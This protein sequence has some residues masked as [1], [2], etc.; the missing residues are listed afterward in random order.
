MRRPQVKTSLIA[1]M[2]LFA[3][4]F[5]GFAVFAI[6]S[7]RQINNE[8]S[9][10]AKNWLPSVSVV[11]NMGVVLGE[12]R[13]AYAN[14]I[15]SISDEAIAAAEL[16]VTEKRKALDSA[17][18]AYIP[19]ISSAREKQLLDLI[20]KEAGEYNT[21]SEPMLEHS[22]ANDNEVAKVI[23]NSEMNPRFEA[24]KTLIDELLGINVS[25]AGQAY[26]S[27]QDSYSSILLQTWI[28]IGLVFTVLLGSIA[29]VVKGI[30]RP[31]NGITAAMRT[32]AAGDTEKTIPFAGR[33]DEIGAMA[34]SVEVFRQAAITNTRLEEAAEGHRGQIEQSRLIKEAEDRSRAE[35]MRQVTTSLGEG[36]IQ[37]SSG[38]L[39]FQLDN[40]FSADFEA[41]R[42]DFN[43]SVRQLGDTLSSIAES[44]SIIDNGTKEISSGA[45]DLSKRTEQQA[46][47]LE[48]TAAALDQITVNVSNSSKRADEA[49]TAATDANQ[50]AA[51]SVE[52]VSHA[53]EAMSRIETSS[54]QIS[55]IIGVI[56][57]IAFQTN[58]LALNAGVEAARAGD[59][60]RGFAV[61]AQEVR[62]L[63]QRSAKAA[64]E[65]K[66]LIHNSTSEVET[67]VKLV[68]ETGLALKAIGEQIAGINMHMESIATSAK[69]QSTGL[70]EVNSA[71]NSMDQTTQ[72]N[73]AMV[74]QSTAASAS[75]A[76]EAAKLR[77]LVAQF[78]LQGATS[79][80][81]TALRQV[82]RVM[83]EPVHRPIRRQQP[84]ALRKVAGVASRTSPATAQDSWE[85]L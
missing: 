1:I 55:N 15:M 28:T 13:F 33:S 47:A 59:A 34:A 85:E 58:L 7:L 72:Q 11:R 45:S 23:F 46:A 52:V 19:L 40:P 9:Q 70:V 4:L 41:L 22:R 36:L 71:V 39:A 6:V 68:R 67:G 8:T 60:G 44:I 27:S 77:D 26:E 16:Q 57:E 64:K 29:Y 43:K 3:V 17:I 83:A 35:S 38:N 5:S 53:V 80:Q 50:S 62:E 66:G 76:M 31:I 12:A 30:S 24:A 56:D 74:E 51:R 25:G 79:M 61:V 78:K 32:L 49:R 14:H 75:L 69:E 65:I 82:A 73:A 42:N 84:V 20:Q 81:P 2:L 10:L 48:E 54:Q 18:K 63:A 37:L 21:S